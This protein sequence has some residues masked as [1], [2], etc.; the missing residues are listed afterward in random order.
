MAW[1]ILGEVEEMM[2]GRGVGILSR[3]RSDRCRE[4][5]YFADGEYHELEEAIADVLKGAASQAQ[6]PAPVSRRRGDE[7][8]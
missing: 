4:K 5:A 6:A 1:K 8:G 3:G 7:D 2:S